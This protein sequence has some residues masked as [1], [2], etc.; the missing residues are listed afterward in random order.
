MTSGNCRLL[1]CKLTI[2][3]LLKYVEGMYVLSHS[4]HVERVSKVK[5]DFFS[6]S[7][8][9]FSCQKMTEDE[10]VVP[11]IQEYIDIYRYIPIYIDIFIVP[12]SCNSVLCVLLLT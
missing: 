3:A 2:L 12:P 4:Y 1:L 7:C 6:L 11:K 9:C 5:P 8:P 10:F